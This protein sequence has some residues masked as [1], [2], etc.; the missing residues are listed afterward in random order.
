MPGFYR[1]VDR[2][3][4]PFLRPRDHRWINHLSLQCM[5]SGEYGQTGDYLPSH[6]VSLS[7]NRCQIILLSDSSMC[8]NNLP[9][10]AMARMHPCNIVMMS[11]NLLATVHVQSLLYGCTEKTAFVSHFISTCSQARL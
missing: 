5:A 3:L 1:I 8:V 6:R 7:H 11:Y 2:V 10:S 9:K 4:I